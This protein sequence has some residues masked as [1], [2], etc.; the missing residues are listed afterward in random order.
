[1]ALKRK[2]ILVCSLLLLLCTNHVLLLTLIH[3]NESSE[4]Y[5]YQ[6]FVKVVGTR[7]EYLN[8]RV[9]YTNQFSV[10]EHEKDVT[11]ANPFSP[12]DG[13]PGIFF[14]YDISPMLVILKEE[15]KPFAHLLT[16]ICAIVGGIFT[17]AGMIDGAI[18]NAEKVFKKKMEL[19][20]A[21]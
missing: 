19:G 2:A 20:K 1:M 15:H 13:L 4:Y 3:P 5:S 11:P 14:S 7:I 21:H 8:K 17:V 12:P 16:D 9:L 10:T 6:Y 18:W